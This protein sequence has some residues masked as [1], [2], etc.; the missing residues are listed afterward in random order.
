MTPLLEMT[1]VEKRLDRIPVLRNID[2]SVHP[3][4][5]TVLIGGSGSGKTTLLRL[6]GGLDRV[7]AGVVR[8]RGDIVD[9]PARGIWAAPERRR[10]GMVFQDYALWPHMTCLENVLAALPE[11][12]SDRVSVARRML[13]R[14]GLGPL[15]ARRPHSLSGGQQQRVGI[16]RALIARPDL[17]LFDEPL[18]GLDV[19]IRDMLRFEIRTLARE[20]GA[21][22]LL[23]SHDPTDAWR[24]ADRVIVLERGSLVQAAAPAEL[25]RDPATARV[26]RFVGAQGGFAARVM[27]NQGI[28]GVEVGGIFH[29]ASSKGVAEG[30]TGV[31]MIRSAGIRVAGEGI[32][33]SLEYTVFEAGRY[34]AYWSCPQLQT[35]LYTAED[36]EP[37]AR[38]ALLSVDAAHLFVYPLEVG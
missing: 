9:A 5:F 32:P 28:L 27:R 37:S 7:D 22:A 12:T 21:G 24:L 34:R 20:S 4:E 10:L 31:V 8:L 38:T 36:R 18:S 35:V 17:V 2:L 23:V 3:G 15:A 1:A 33:A 13:E 14:V 26:A 19:D 29:A 6:V 25:Y 30:E 11:G 16:A